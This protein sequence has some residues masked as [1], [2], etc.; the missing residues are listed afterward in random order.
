MVDETAVFDVQDLAVRIHYFPDGNGKLLVQR[1]KA[2]G[3]VARA[4]EIIDQAA[5]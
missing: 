2:L 1:F 4:L 3:D 5:F